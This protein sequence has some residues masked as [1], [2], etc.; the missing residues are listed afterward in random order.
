[1]NLWRRALWGFA[2]TVAWARIGSLVQQAPA[3]VRNRSNPLAA[4]AADRRKALCS[5]MPILP[6]T[7]TRRNRQGPP[8]E[9]CRRVPSGPGCTLLGPAP[10]IPSSGHAVFCSSAR[11]GAVAGHHF[12]S[13]GQRNIGCNS[14]VVPV[15]CLPSKPGSERRLSRAGRCLIPKGCVPRPEENQSGPVSTRTFSTSVPVLINL[16]TSLILI[17]RLAFTVHINFR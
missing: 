15:S 14:I 12:S 17:D 4:G 9:Q 5:R 3:G 2:V 13:G 11:T 8:A 7:Q 1:M 16:R 10:R 6:W